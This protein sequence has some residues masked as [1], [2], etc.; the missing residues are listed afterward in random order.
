[1]PYIHTNKERDMPENLSSIITYIIVASIVILFVISMKK[2]VKRDFKNEIVSLGVLGTFLG[3]SLGLFHFDVTDIKTSLPLLLEGL[4]T[5]FITS[6]VGIFF[7]IIISVYKPVKQ[8][9][10]EILKS[11]QNIVKEFNNN[12]TEEFGENFKE[13]NKAV[14]NMITWQENYKSQIAKN[15]ESLNSIL[16]ELQTITLF[17]ENQEKQISK[18]IENLTNSSYEVKESLQ[19][20]TDIVKENLQLLLREANGKLL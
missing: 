18:V 16:K 10:S 5:A 19:E 6:G 9:N 20:A 12:L 1:M 15:E 11:L 3:I 2:G 7:S 8:N 17:K 13:L 14:A 4:K